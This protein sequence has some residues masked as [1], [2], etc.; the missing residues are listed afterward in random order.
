[1]LQKFVTLKEQLA[2]TSKVS[3]EIAPVKNKEFILTKLKSEYEA[4]VSL[5]A[6]GE[7]DC[8]LCIYGSLVEKL[9]DLDYVNTIREI[10]AKECYLSFEQIP[11]EIRL[12]FLCLKNSAYICEE[13]GYWEEMEYLYSI[14][15]E[16]FVDCVFLDA[17]LII[18]MLRSL[19]KIGALS[20]ARKICECYL[21]Q[22]SDK[23]I[24]REWCSLLHLI[25][26]NLMYELQSG[27]YNS[28]W[29]STS[30]DTLSLRLSKDLDIVSLEVAKCETTL[31]SSY[32]V[33]D[34]RSL[35]L[36]I[37]LGAFYDSASVPFDFKS[38]VSVVKSQGSRGI[39]DS[40]GSL[41][42]KVSILYLGI[43]FRMIRVAQ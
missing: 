23:F 22:R 31:E 29:S 20:F 15:V 40:G 17:G 38:L 34:A 33:T 30:Q 35:L 4:G 19:R 13:K 26:D 2:E 28:N 21:R 42:F 16:S 3:D 5:Q 1:M 32:F 10:A 25:G 18:R 11:F 9:S 37:L 43:H 14:L 24:Y 39:L 36:W 6:K 8:A 27:N 12:H 7:L 41:I